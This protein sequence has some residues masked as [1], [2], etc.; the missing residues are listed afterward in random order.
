MEVERI[1][2]NTRE[3]Q[4][5]P[6]NSK[7]LEGTPRKSMEVKGIP[8][9]TLSRGQVVWENGE[10]KTVRGAGINVKRPPFPSY[11]DAIHRQNELAIPTPVDRS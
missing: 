7:E 11:W 3:P 5:T 8:A 6:R 1:P 9:Y 4:G 10:L 2:R